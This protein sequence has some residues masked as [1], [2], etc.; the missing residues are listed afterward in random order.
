MI[1][2]INTITGHSRIDGVVPGVRGQRAFPNRELRTLDPFVMLDH[3]GPQH[4]GTEYYVDG[5]NSSHPH[6]GFETLTFMF[7]GQMK[8]VDSL[9]NKAELKTGDVQRMNAGRGIQHGGDFLSDPSTGNFHEVQLWVN[10]PANEKMSE[11]NIHNVKSHE[12]PMV[13]QQNQSIRVICGK[14]LGVQ[15]P[16]ETL[17]TTQIAHVISEAKGKVKI[18]GLTNSNNVGAYVLKGS[19]SMDGTQFSQGEMVVFNKDGDEL[20]LKAAYAGELLV[21]SGKP[22][23]Q[24]V[25]MGGPFVM[26]TQD[27]IEQAYQDFDKGLFGTI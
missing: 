23:N 22:L 2:T 24:P 17:A 20:E 25:V 27:E 4:L 5:S 8:H 9:G 16:M 1:R 12:F 18:T 10:A 21:I 11:P 13:T 6:R 26:N 7:D 19:Y 3:I 15:G 14:L